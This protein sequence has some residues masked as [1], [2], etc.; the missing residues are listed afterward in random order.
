MVASKLSWKGKFLIVSALVGVA[1]SFLASVVL[2][3]SLKGSHE[4]LLKKEV[5]PAWFQKDRVINP[6]RIYFELDDNNN[7]E[8]NIYHSGMYLYRNNLELNKLFKN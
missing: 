5:F 8:P 2:A 4:S 1:D 3:K 6:E 7:N